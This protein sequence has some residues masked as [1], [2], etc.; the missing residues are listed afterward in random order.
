MTKYGVLS[1]LINDEK[2]DEKRVFSEEET[3]RSVV[4]F[5]EIHHIKPDTDYCFIL[6]FQSKMNKTTTYGT[7]IVSKRKNITRKANKIL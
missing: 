7:A 3:K 5:K 2:V 1:L 6:T 4:N